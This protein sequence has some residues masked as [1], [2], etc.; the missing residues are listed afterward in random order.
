MRNCSLENQT[1]TSVEVRCYAGY[2]GGLPQEFI[3]EVYHGDLESLANIRPLYNVSAKDEPSFVLTGLQASVDAGVHVAVYAVNA[4]GRSQP[5]VLSEVTFRDAEKRTGEC[6]FFSARC[7]GNGLFLGILFALML[8]Y[9]GVIISQ[10]SR[11][12]RGVCEEG[13]TTKRKKVLYF[14]L[15]QLEH[16]NIIWFFSSFSRGKNN[17]YYVDV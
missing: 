16:K 9:S 8:D 10:D 1:Y 14:S 13:I 2:D 4:K 17:I 11:I 5:V 6:L 12:H 3:L 15:D 7:W